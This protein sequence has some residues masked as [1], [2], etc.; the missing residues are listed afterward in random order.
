MVVDRAVGTTSQGELVD[1]ARAERDLLGT[2]VLV[3]SP[4]GADAGDPRAAG[5]DAWVTKPVGR[6]ALLDGVVH[7]VAR[8]RDA[9]LPRGGRHAS[10]PPSNAHG[11]V[12]LVEDNKVNQTVALAFLSALGYE[13]DVAVDGLAALDAIE[14]RS[15]DAVLMDCQM[16]RMDGYE[17]TR[18]IR[19]REGAGPRTP[20][21]AMTASAMQSDR[22]RCLAEGM[23]DHVPKPVRRDALAAVLSRWIDGP[24][25]GGPTAPP[26]PSVGGRAGRRP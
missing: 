4:A 11:R 12:L 22:D 19:R 3:M 18:E 14:A 24:A 26:V 25:T 7:A 20:I 8:G 21:V 15:Y 13:A 17:A 23:D 10:D 5:A 1:D 9:P 16:P 6:A 2:R